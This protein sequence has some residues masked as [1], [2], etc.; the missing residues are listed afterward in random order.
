L[1]NLLKKHIDELRK[2][3]YIKIQFNPEDT[4]CQKPKS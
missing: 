1:N 3:S 2:K 4:S